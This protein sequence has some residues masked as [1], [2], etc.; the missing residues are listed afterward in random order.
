MML[1]GGRP[2]AVHSTN[3]FCYIIKHVWCRWRGSLLA[4]YLYYRVHSEL[5]CWLATC[6]DVCMLFLVHNISQM[7]QLVGV[8]TKYVNLM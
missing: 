6:K 4:T 1:I 5:L 2:V 8:Y 7:L 3:V